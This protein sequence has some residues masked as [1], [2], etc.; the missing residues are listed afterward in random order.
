MNVQMLFG[1]S[2]LMSFV[3]WSL[4]ARLYVWRWLKSLSRNDALA[5]LIVPHMFRFVGLSF[6]VPG[7]VS[8]LLPSS[9][10]APAAYGDFIAALLAVA[11]VIALRWHVSWAIAL[12][13]LFNLW[14]S[15]DL[16]YAIFN[17]NVLS[18]I[19]ASMLGAAF[20]IPTFIVPFLLVSHALTFR[21]LLSRN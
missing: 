21:L 9:F 7:V 17:G 10:A 20:F 14:G 4:V 5:A 19:D 12:T 16:L 11:V 8:P 18:H 15:A 1:L 3:A 2:A 6:L 13:W